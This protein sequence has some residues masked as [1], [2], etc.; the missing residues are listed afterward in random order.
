[1]QERVRPVVDL[2]L[3][4]GARSMEHIIE[5]TLADLCLSMM[6]EDSML[7]MINNFYLFVLSCFS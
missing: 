3:P 1:M 5:W 4:L 7:D 2:V 6:N